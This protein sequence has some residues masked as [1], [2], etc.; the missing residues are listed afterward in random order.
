MFHCLSF[1]VRMVTTRCIERLI[2][3]SLQVHQCHRRKFAI[4]T[5]PYTHSYCTLVGNC[6]RRDATRRDRQ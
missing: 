1:A 5:R 2:R 3:C 4:A 6:A